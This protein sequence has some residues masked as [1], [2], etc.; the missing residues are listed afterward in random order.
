VVAAMT[1]RALLRLTTGV[2]RFTICL[3][4]IRGVAGSTHPRRV[5]TRV[6]SGEST[7]WAA[8]RRFGESD[9]TNH[10]AVP[11]TCRA[12]HAEDC[13]ATPVHTYSIEMDRP[14]GN[15]S[16]SSNLRDLKQDVKRE[17]I[18]D[19]ESSATLSVPK[20]SATLCDLVVFVEEPTESVPSVTL[21]SASMES[22]SAHSG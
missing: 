6:M 12:T 18:G 7:G 5:A 10:V 15:S 4:V 19:I 3:P 13:V 17:L 9:A 22:G 20:K 1:T 2:N 16:H 11:V 14:K 8:E 21:M